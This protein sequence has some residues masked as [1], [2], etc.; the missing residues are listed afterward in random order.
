MDASRISKA[1][2]HRFEEATAAPTLNH[3]AR[4]HNRLPKLQTVAQ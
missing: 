3:Q 2:R 1:I 4:G